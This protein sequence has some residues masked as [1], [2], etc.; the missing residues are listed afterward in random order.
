MPLTGPGI[1]NRLLSI[2]P[3]VQTMTLRS[4]AAGETFTDVSW[5][6][7]QLPVN[8]ELMQ[9]SPG[10][11]GTSSASFE[12]FQQAQTVTPRVKDK[13]IVGGLIWRIDHV[14]Q[15]EQTVIFEVLATKELA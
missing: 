7:R 8:A 13:L 15:K 1:V 14:S 6:G 2:L 10:L 5:K 12:L 4:R 11:L 9:A 3:N